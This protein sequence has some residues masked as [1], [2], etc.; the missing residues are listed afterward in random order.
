MRCA[1]FR[2][3]LMITA[4]CP[5]AIARTFRNNS[6]SFATLAAMRRASSLLSNWHPEYGFVLILICVAL[7]LVVAS[8]MFTPVGGEITLVGPY[9][10]P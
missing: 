7:A 5:S 6:A 8:V 1:L 2:M 4:L 3:L 10:G 9:V